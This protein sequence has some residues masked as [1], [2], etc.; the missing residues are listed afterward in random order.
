MNHARVKALKRD[1]K[2]V[3]RKAVKSGRASSGL[4]PRSSPMASLLTSPSH[5]AAPSRVASDV[6]DDDDE[7][8][9]DFDAMSLSG[10][11]VGSLPEITEDGSSNIDVQALIDQLQDRKHSNNELREH[12][13]GVFIRL[14]RTQYSP[15]T[16]NWLDAAADDLAEHFLK[17]GDRAATARERLLNLQAYCLLVG[18]AEDLDV[19]ESGFKV[20]KQ[21]II[22]EDDD[23]CRSQAIIA[24]CMTVLY[25]GGGEEA[26]LELMEFFI[27]VVQSDG[28]SIQ[29]YDNGP[30]VAAIIQGWAFTASHVSDFSDYAD[31]ALDAFV[32]QLDGGDSDV[33]AAAAFCIALIFESSRS[34]EEETGEPF[35]LGYDPHRL[36]D[37]VG[38]LLKV[39]AKSVSRKGRREL[40]ENLVSVMTSLERGVGPFYST[41][42]Y[43]P[44]KESHVPASQMNDNGQAEY[45][46]RGKIR[47]GNNVAKITT[48]SLLARFNVMKSIFRGG[49]HKHIFANPVVMECL[50]DAHFQQGPEVETPRVKGRKR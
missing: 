24:L 19:F 23:D 33:Q 34:H 12:H 27:D 46:Y 31:V 16:H 11:S 1:G 28:E 36:A 40:R 25:G 43:I 14:L 21:I 42:L 2:T 35:Q 17:D 29:A 38:E 37:R 13:L 7:L 3:S 47:I 44:D 26:A 8:E 30:I 39:S 41:A 15:E 50:E 10:H 49:L 32:D 4:T 20:L 6:S 18:T 9:A 5:S 45:G 48:W 22:D